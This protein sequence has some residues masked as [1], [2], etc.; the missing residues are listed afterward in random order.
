M[1]VPSRTVASLIE[2]D[3]AKPQLHPR[4]RGVVAAAFAV[5]ALL[6]FAPAVSAGPAANDTIYSFSLSGSPFAQDF[7]PLPTSV[8]GKFVLAR[9]AYVSVR[10]FRE[11]G[12]QVRVIQPR[13]RRAAGTYSFAWNGR[14]SD[15]NM[16]ADGVYEI[17]VKAENGMGTMV[18]KQVV[19]KGLPAIYPQNPGAIV[20]AVDPGHGGRLVGAATGP[21]AEKTFN[22]D[23][24]LR[25]R[26]LLTHAGVQVV[27][28]RTTDVAVLEPK[29]DYNGDGVL[30]RYDDDL[31]RNDIKNRARVDVAVHVHNNGSSNVDDSGTGTFIPEFRSWTETARVLATGMDAEQFA[32]LVPYT[33]GAF[34]PKDNGVKYGRFYYYMAPYD[35]PFLP[36]PSLVTSVLSESLFVTNAA[37]LEML[38]RVDV[39]TSLAAAIYLGLARW[40]NSR[41]LGIGYELVNGPSAP[42][43]SSS[44]LSYR[45]RVTNRGNEPSSGWNLQLHNVAA[46][47]EYDGSGQLGSL[48]GSVAVPDG[49]APGA[50]VMLDVSATAPATAGSWLVKSDVRLADSSYASAH[51]VVVLQTVLTTEST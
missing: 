20:I 12:P 43:A 36:R 50:S 34:V 4:A 28:T 44:P 7:A 45:I 25:L 41:D 17:R 31:M 38:K 37:D 1:A 24:G 16:L 2:G 48:M 5:F 15:G 42:V 3:V 11:G 46:A 26:D 21:F 13:K 49:L 32:A 18:K 22:L 19:R 10:V 6:Q 27:M 14:G 51:G 8:T 47:P 30:N 23:I 40:L 35:P 29:S 9:R 33:S 39:R